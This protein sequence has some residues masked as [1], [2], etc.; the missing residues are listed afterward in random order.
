MIMLYFIAVGALVIL[1]RIVSMWFTHGMERQV[2]MGPAGHMGAGHERYT[3]RALLGLRDIPTRGL[4]VLAWVLR[5]LIVATFFGQ[6][7]AVYMAFSIGSSVPDC[8][9]CQFD[10]HGKSALFWA[11]ML[12]AVIVIL[13]PDLVGIMVMRAD[14]R[15]VEATSRFDIRRMKMGLRWIFQ[16]RPMRADAV[17]GWL[18]HVCRWLIL[19][20]ILDALVIAGM[21]LLR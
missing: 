1:T 9:A 7:G 14:P 4:R 17:A 11:A 21:M 12:L 13:V 15:Q 3:N 18:R 2:D 20:G 19:M 10:P 5:A 16:D 6:V 8:E